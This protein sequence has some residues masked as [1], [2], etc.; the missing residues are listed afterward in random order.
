MHNEFYC[1]KPSF[2][3]K[4]MSKRAM[5]ENQAS[6]MGYVLKEKA[7]DLEAQYPRVFKLNGREAIINIQGPLSPDGPDAIDVYLGF[8]GTAYKNI[9]RAAKEARELYDSGRIDNV[10]VKINS[11][12]GIVDGLDQAYQDLQTIRSIGIVRNE[13]LIASA[14]VWLACAFDKIIPGTDSAQIGSIGVV[15]DYYD[16][17]GFYESN[18]FDH[19]IIT[20]TESPDKRPDTKTEEGIDV[21][22]KELDELY[23]VFVSKVTAARPITKTQIDAL[24]GAVVIA[25]RAVE[26]GLM[27]E[28]PD[29]ARSGEAK[30]EDEKEERKTDMENEKESAKTEELTPSVDAG[31]EER[32]R[33]YGLMTVAGITVSDD[34]KTAIETGVSVG[35]YAIMSMQAKKE[36]EKA[37]VEAARKARAVNADQKIT[38]SAEQKIESKGGDAEKIDALLDARYKKE[39]K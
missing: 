15:V 6:I 24:R 23:N 7:D 20:N 27:D 22:R 9:S 21:V 12:G 33:L 36:Q 28:Q 34:L 25:S 2:L 14:A 19:V 4:R 17:D 26:L 18:G 38:I 1:I 13:G 16:A 37:E 29:P 3:Q 30:K 31:A 35:D 39:D 5:T 11:P 32:K 10:V 8:G